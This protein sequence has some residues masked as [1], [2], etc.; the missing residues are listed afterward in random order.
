MI[1]EDRLPRSD[2]GEIAEKVSAPVVAPPRIRVERGRI[3]R[4]AILVMLAT[5]VAVLTLTLPFWATGFQVRVVTSMFMFAILAESWNIITGFVGYP[6]F[7]NTVFFG[8]GAY[9][10]ALSTKAGVPVLLAIPLASIGATAVGLVIG[11]PLLR[12]RGH[13]FAI[14]TMALSLGV[15]GI[16]SNLTPITGG[17]S[18]I[19]LPISRGEPREIFAQYYFLMLAILLLS[20][21]TTYWISVSRFGYGLRTIKTD[22]A[23]AATLGIATARYKVAAWSISAFYTAMA[24]GVWALWIT[25]I[26]PPSAFSLDNAVKFSVMALL[27]GLGTVWGPVIAALV[28]EFIS[29]LVWQSFITLHL[30]ILGLV[31]MITV[32]VAPSGVMELV[33]SKPVRARIQKAREGLQMLRQRVF[34]QSSFE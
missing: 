5:L 24:G 25:Y 9:V 26:D 10:V 11:S 8:L 19:V 2:E 32:L 34:A 1:H 16:T 27:G 15:Q 6:A 29:V 4:Q 23:A 17:S 13:Y 30:A 14:A 31:I 7:G 12:L 20:I 22:E 33:R 18:G 21:G 28:V 3:V